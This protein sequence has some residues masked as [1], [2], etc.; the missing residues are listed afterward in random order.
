MLGIILRPRID[1]ITD[2]QQNMLGRRQ[3]QHRKFLNSAQ[4]TGEWSISRPGHFTDE[5]STEPVWTVLEKRK[6]LT[7]TGIRTPERP[8][9]A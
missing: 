3:V 9:R 6:P 8:A 4:G 7:P 5:W 2:G 1:Q